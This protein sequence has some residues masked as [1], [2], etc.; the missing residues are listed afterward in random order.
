MSHLGL[1]KETLR[2]LS[3][4]AFLPLSSRA[5][6][7]VRERPKALTFLICRV[8]YGHRGDP[9]TCSGQ[10]NEK[11]VVSFVE[12]KREPS[13]CYEV[14]TGGPGAPGSAEQSAAMDDGR[15][16]ALGVTGTSS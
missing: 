9:R 2:R 8:V 1:Q 15:G 6:R 7:R 13:L 4:K 14:L 16:R 12:N 11:G 3:Q 5:A 10:R